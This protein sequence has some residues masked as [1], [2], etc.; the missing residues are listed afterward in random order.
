M[1]ALVGTA[2]AGIGALALAAA[3][4]AAQQDVGVA[5]PTAA[6]P[7]AEA[8]ADDGAAEAPDA[9]LGDDAEA[10]GGDLEAYWDRRLARARQRIEIAHERM[11]KA[12]AE[13]SRA[14]HDQYPRGEALAEIE[15]RHRAAV[16]EL[17]AAETAL[18]QLVEQARRAGV[19]PGVLR[20]YWDQDANEPS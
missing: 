12:E 15:E 3:P 10:G 19:S 4:A 9:D 8:P 5:E 17:Q 13:Y 6:A 14:R 20:E 18:P 7:A 2:A 16:R 1:G 11:A